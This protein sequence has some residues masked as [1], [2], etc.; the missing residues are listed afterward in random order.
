MMGFA[1]SPNRVASPNSLSGLDRDS[2]GRQQ[3]KSIAQGMLK[4]GI[5]LLPQKAQKATKTNGN[6]TH[7]FHLP[8]PHALT[9]RPSCFEIGRSCWIFFC[10]KPAP[11]ERQLGDYSEVPPPPSDYFPLPKARSSARKTVKVALG[12]NSR[13]RHLAKFGEMACLVKH[14]WRGRRYETMN[15]AS[16]CC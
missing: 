2:F 7:S 5:R 4:C 11:Q 8:L 1:R 16:G 15:S 10:P 14:G 6:H 3:Q 12:C 9:L 13:S